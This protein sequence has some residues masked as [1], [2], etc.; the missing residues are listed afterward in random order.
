MNVI[1][2]KTKKLFLNN[3]VYNSICIALSVM[4]ISIFFSGPN[5]MFSFENSEYEFLMKLSYS[6]NG[7]IE[8]KILKRHDPRESHIGNCNTDYWESFRTDL[9]TDLVHE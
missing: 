1:W 7:E 6:E 3:Y 4:L 2:S 5:G 9:V 8:R